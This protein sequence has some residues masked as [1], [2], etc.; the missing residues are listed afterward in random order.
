MNKPYK[1]CI[2]DD[3]EI[4]KF[5]V[6]STLMIKKLAREILE[7]SDGEEALG[8]MTANLSNHTQLPDVILLD[9][10]MPIM[11]GFQFIE[12]YIKIKPS[13]SKK[14]AIYMVSSSLDPIDL[15]KAKTYN[16]ISDYI[17][18]P[19]KPTELFEIVN[20]LEMAS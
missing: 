18:K 20:R 14:I 7:F 10:N 6:T 4:Y 13:V 16:E 17:V 15:D 1:I 5:T 11:D 12:E 8:F 9:I 3:D 2:I 19:I